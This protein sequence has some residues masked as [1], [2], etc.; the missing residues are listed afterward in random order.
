MFYKVFAKKL[1]LPG[2]E[3]VGVWPN[4]L[5]EGIPSRKNFNAIVGAIPASLVGSPADESLMI[6]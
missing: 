2:G 4:K 6:P 3:F 1:K 5:A